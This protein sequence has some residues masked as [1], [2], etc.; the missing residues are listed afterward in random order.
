[1]MSKPPSVF[2]NPD[3]KKTHINPN[4][5]KPQVSASIHVNPSFLHK[6]QKEEK[7]K[8]PGKIIAVSRTKL[9]RESTSQPE[10]L[11]PVKSPLIRVGTRKLVRA[12]LLNAKPPPIAK[13][14]TTTRKIQPKRDLLNLKGKY[15]IDRR[16]LSA[17]V[18]KGKSFVSK[19]ALSRVSAIESLTPKRVIVSNRRISKLVSGSSKDITKGTVLLNINGVFYKSTKNKLQKTDTQR[20][21]PKHK[22]SGERVLFVR[23]DKYILDKSGHNLTR[24]QQPKADTFSLKRIDIG[25]LTYVAKSGNTFI[26]TD[27]HRART[28]LSSAKQKSINLLSKRLVKSN[29]PCPIFRKV[30]KCAAFERGKC[31]KI[32]DKKHVAICHKYLKGEC[33]SEK[34]LLSHDV[35]LAKMPTCKFFLQGCCVRTD[36]PYLHKKLNER[37]EICLEFLKGF[38]KLADKC[39]KR[40]EFLCPDFA[41]KG[42]CE[43]T[44]CPYMH[45]RKEVEKKESGTVEL[46]GEQVAITKEKTNSRYFLESCKSEEEDEVSANEPQAGNSKE[47]EDGVPRRPK[48]GT[49]PAFIPL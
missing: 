45:N 22:S 5:L 12:S 35:T 36:C 20:E 43:R 17:K 44:R 39:N 37:T 18:T 7:P 11:K 27:I 28:H 40:H 25:G 42:K 23:G 16:A 10:T 46:V 29:I 19:Y 3:F 2:I 38:C 9:I 33:I 32:H 15:K 31:P 6:F 48:L 13:Q 4:F 1:M 34:C 49:L 47:E 14:I 21:S 26:R 8:S 24:V 30:G 41:S